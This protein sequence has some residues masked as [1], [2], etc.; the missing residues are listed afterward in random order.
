VSKRNSVPRLIVLIAVGLV[1]LL[2]AGCTLRV[3]ARSAHVRFGLFPQDFGPESQ[4]IIARESNMIVNHHLSW[5]VIEPA[6]GQ[7]NFAPADAVDEF[8]R[9]HGLRE[10]GF[11]FAWDNELLDDFPA[12]VGEITDPDE[13]RA[14][15]RERARRI[16]ERYRHLR[17]VDVINEPLATFGSTLV[18][19]HFH[20]VLGADYIAQLFEIVDEEA[21]P[22]T[23]LFVNENF[24]EYF[25]AKADA[26]VELVGGLLD[27]GARVDAVGLQTHLLLGEPDWGLMRQTMERLEALG[28]N[29]MVTELDVPVAPALPDRLQVQADRYRRVVEACLAVRACDTVNVW[30]VDDRYTWLD[31]VLGPGTD[32]LLFDR[33]GDRKPAYFAVREALADGRPRG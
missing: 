7:W 26:L 16:F 18:E 8:A 9:R 19:N 12:W 23:R 22:S 3:A 32:P 30:G 28:V 5:N 2:L 6:R 14:V 11:H 4:A 13:L 15:I 17:A 24:V 27:R 25:P 1:V 31:S 29:V 10:F 21:P 20:R 33:S